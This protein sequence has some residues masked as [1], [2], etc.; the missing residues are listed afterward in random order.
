MA[1]RKAST[2]CGA[3]SERP[4]RYKHR[5][6]PLPR[7][8]RAGASLILRAGKALH[9]LGCRLRPMGRH[10]W[11]ESSAR[12]MT[13]WGFLARPAAAPPVPDPGRGVKKQAA[14]LTGRT[15]YIP[16]ERERRRLI[17]RDFGRPFHVRARCWPRQYY[18][19]SCLKD[20]SE[21]LPYVGIQ[22]V[23]FPHATSYLPIV[24]RFAPAVRSPPQILVFA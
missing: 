18:W 7:G 24:Q 3:A 23:F 22:E 1:R 19:L 2:G 21:E 17:S 16:L 14:N 8:A 12:P 10:E 6:H 11:Q 20:L 5:R 9:L 15:C 13:P 4:T